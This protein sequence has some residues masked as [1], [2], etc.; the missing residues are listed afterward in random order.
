[1]LT[2][3]KVII[4]VSVDFRSTSANVTSNDCR[5]FYSSFLRRPNGPL[6]KTLPFMAI[7]NIQYFSSFCIIR[8]YYAVSIFL[9]NLSSIFSFTSTHRIIGFFPVSCLQAR[10][11]SRPLFEVQ[12]KNIFYG[13]FSHSFRKN[14]WS[15]LLISGMFRTSIY[16]SASAKIFK[17]H[18]VK[19]R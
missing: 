13:R 4:V 7:W 15:W 19:S 9:S 14:W 2:I 3:I 16:K 10:N 12:I 18:L 11:T 6:S 5:R 17:V 8:L 1:M